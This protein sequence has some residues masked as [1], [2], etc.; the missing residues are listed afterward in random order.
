[1][2]KMSEQEFIER[3]GKDRAIAALAVLVED[4]VSGKKRVI[5]DST[6]GVL[7][8]HRIRCRDKVRMPGPREKRYL[9]EEF[10][11]NKEVVISMVG[12]FE[13]A[14]RR[15][16]YQKSERG[17]LGCKASSSSN[18]VYVNKVGTF[19]IG[20]TPYWW[21]RI[22]GAL[23]RLVHY[24][25]GE[26]FPIEL[27][28]YADDLEIMAPGRAGREGALMAFCLMAALG[29]P[30]KWK[31]QRGG[32]S[33]EWVGIFVD[34]RDYSMGL[35][36]RRSDWMVQWIDSL[37][38][39]KVV[40]YR[41]FAAGLGRMGFAAL[42]LPWE[43]PLLG[44]L[45]AWSSAVRGNHGR[46]SL[47]WAVLFLLKWIRNRL[48]AGNHMEK[49]KNTARYPAETLRVWTDAKATE[50]GAW[51][52]GWL[53]ESEDLKECEWF[54]EEVRE[55]RAP[56]LRCRGGNPKRVIAALEMLATLVALRL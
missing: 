10:E 25:L 11:A 9:L 3:Y 32:L 33:S 18:D 29:A 49:V 46:L 45:Y 17:F 43:R 4:E 12:D 37:L 34:Y 20:S 27:L 22:S 24:V 13:K 26:R 56:W 5:H 23:I 53:Q 48:V 55:E 30:F 21:T 28:L 39:R 54:A 7:V 2:E 6:H 36:Q 19:G 16:I 15:F 51:I 38:E 50:D 44:P 35:S 52:G 42:A 31:K 8:N 47:P 14:H 1:M 40:E 41:E